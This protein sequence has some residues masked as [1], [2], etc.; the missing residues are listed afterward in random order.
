[1]WRSSRCNSTAPRTLSTRPSR[2]A[3]STSTRT[4]TCRSGWTSRSSC[5]RATRWGSRKTELVPGLRHIPAQPRGERRSAAEYRGGWSADLAD[6][7]AEEA[8][9]GGEQLV[10]GGDARRLEG[11]ARLRGARLDQHQRGAAGPGV[12]A[13]Q[14]LQLGEPVRRRR[15]E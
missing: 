6:L 14:R 4:T 7:L 2:S 9:D 10:V 13:E 8:V 1:M 3:G 5:A 15:L 11:D 12:L